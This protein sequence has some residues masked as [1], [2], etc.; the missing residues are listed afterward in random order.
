[1]EK[2]TWK[3]EE[4]VELKDIPCYE[5]LYAI[6]RDG[7]VWS[8]HRCRRWLKFG[9]TYGKLGVVLS[10]NGYKTSYTISHLIGITYLNVSKKYILHKDGDKKNN[11]IKNIS[12]TNI[13]N[14]HLAKEINQ[15]TKDCLY[16]K[17]FHSVAEA[18]RLLNIFPTNITRCARGKYKLAGGYIWKYCED[19]KS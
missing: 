4:D 10:R 1:M 3:P 15:Y 18:G 16:I 7:R 14:G 8:Y 19:D 2:L 11:S 9:N 6:T 5:G 17:T 13:R 12:F